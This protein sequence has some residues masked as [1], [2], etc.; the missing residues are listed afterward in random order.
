MSSISSEIALDRANEAEDRVRSAVEDN[1]RKVWECI[2]DW[3]L[4]IAVE[5]L[6]SETAEP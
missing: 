4:E 6:A 2:R 5:L 1:E 3:W